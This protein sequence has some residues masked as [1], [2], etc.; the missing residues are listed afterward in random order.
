MGSGSCEERALRKE[1]T[2]KW[3]FKIA[4]KHEFSI[5]LSDL[6]NKSTGHTVKFEFQRSNK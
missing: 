4:L 1:K 6:V 5:G 3:Y 2:K